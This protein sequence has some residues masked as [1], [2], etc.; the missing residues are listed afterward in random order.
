MYTMKII[1]LTALLKSGAACDGAGNETHLRH[2]RCNFWYVLKTMYSLY[3]ASQ[4]AV[5]SKAAGGRRETLVSPGSSDEEA[6]R[7]STMETSIANAPGCEKKWND[8]RT[9]ATN[10][11]INGEA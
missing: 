4:R 11:F 9:S 5:I 7:G 10:A 2:A 3:T 6:W 8:D 1:V